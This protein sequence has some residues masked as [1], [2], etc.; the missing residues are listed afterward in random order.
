MIIWRCIELDRKKQ[1]R[2]DYNASDV[3]VELV[4]GLV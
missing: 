2:V 3:S 1:S 4:G